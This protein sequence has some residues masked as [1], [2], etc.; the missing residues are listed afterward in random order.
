MTENPYHPPAA[1]HHD[2]ESDDAEV[3]IQ[4]PR[5]RGSL[6]SIQGELTE[7]DAIKMAT[8]CK[9]IEIA[10]ENP[11]PKRPRILSTS[12]LLLV[13]LAAALMMVVFDRG[14]Q[15]LS[16]TSP[17][18]VSPASD[19]DLGMLLAIGVPLVILAALFFL[20]RHWRVRYDN[21]D[22]PLGGPIRIHLN[23]LG[24]SIEKET[25]DKRLIE[26]FCSWRQMHVTESADAWLLN[27]GMVNPFLIAK[28]FLP[29]S[30]ERAYFDALAAD[31]TRWQS[32][33]SPPL[34][35]D[36]IPEEAGESFPNYRDGTTPLTVSSSTERL[37][38]KSVHAALRGELPEYKHSVPFWP[39]FLWRSFLLLLIATLLYVLISNDWGRLESPWNVI[40]WQVV[41]LVVVIGIGIRVSFLAGR[42]IQVAGAISDDDLWYDYRSLLLR[43][44]LSTLPF[45]KM[46]AGNLVLA[47]PTGST[48]IVLHPNHFES[49]EAFQEQANRLI[50]A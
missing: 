45:R 3:E 34:Q 46:I 14:P 13:I 43:L 37:A 23:E 41:P 24:C 47:T 12:L 1:T 19:V 17:T 40:L 28:S 11:E 25:R 29:T 35:L 16:R 7:S 27:V 48:T 5:Y 44:P 22:P 50:G 20:I 39:K 26:V 30:D 9:P 38:R 49:P 31:I 10:S 33:Q 42:E 32:T 8:A 36:S 2:P 6:E 21:A 18:G 4:P 15:T